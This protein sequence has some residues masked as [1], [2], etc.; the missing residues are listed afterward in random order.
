MLF[1]LRTSSVRRLVCAV[2]LLLPL[3]PNAAAACIHDESPAMPMS[4]HAGHGDISH[5]SGGDCG[6]PDCRI[7]C[8]GTAATTSV[9]VAPTAVN[10]GQFGPVQ[11]TAPRAG[12]PHRLLRPPLY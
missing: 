7:I 9:Q 11:A 10:P 12:H 3:M 5:S 1:R 6:D 2:A 4:S 8:A